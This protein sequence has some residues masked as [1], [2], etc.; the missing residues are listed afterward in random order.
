MQAI[1]PRKTHAEEA[2]LPSFQRLARRPKVKVDFSK[3]NDG[4]DWARAILARS[5]AGESI[6]AYTLLSARQAL[7]GRSYGL[8]LR[9]KR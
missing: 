5:E 4:K 7:G 8:A 1:T 2:G 9:N 3:Q 6:R